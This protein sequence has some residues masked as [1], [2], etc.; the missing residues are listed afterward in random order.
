MV[1]VGEPASSTRTRPSVSMLGWGYDEEENLPIYL[2]RAE[3]FL[4]A[5]SDDFELIVIDDG[6]RDRMWE[7]AV[8]A[9]QTRPWL[10]VFKNDRNRGAAYS[11]KRAI[12]AA[13]KDY[14]FWQTLDWAYDLTHLAGAFEDLGTYDV[15]QGVRINALDATA[16][17]LRSDS[18]WKGL[19]SHANYRLVRLLFRLPINDYQNVTVY[20]TKLVQ[21]FEFEADSS[22]MNP[23]LLLKAWWSG[24]SFK[25]VPVPFLKRERGVAKG[26][27]FRSIVRSVR[28]IFYWWI[29]W[30]LLGRR[31]QKGRGR[32]V[33]ISSADLRS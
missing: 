2:E 3:R 32:V 8:E 18:S 33:Q 30:I 14:L 20:P 17:G 5:I 1:A 4:R 9:Q 31:R 26:T 21:S 27:R 6:S 22:F 16:F 29:V 24:A 28:D 13:T 25:E 11:A 19:V 7:L 12:R 10:R 23:E 15:L